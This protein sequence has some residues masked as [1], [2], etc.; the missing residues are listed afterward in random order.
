MWS[1][2]DPDVVRLLEF[3]RAMAALRQQTPTREWPLVRVREHEEVLVIREWPNG[4][5]T[6]Y[7]IAEPSHPSDDGV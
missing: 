4:A 3:V 2:F 5:I 6:A 7:A 1:G